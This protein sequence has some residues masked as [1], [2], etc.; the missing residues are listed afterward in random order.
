M[1]VQLKGSGPG[2]PPM[3]P[4]VAVPL[5]AVGGFVAILFFWRTAIRVRHRQRSKAALQVDNQSQLSRTGGVNAS[6]KKHI[7]YAPLWGFRHSREFRLFGL[8]M[9]SIP[10][11][12]EVILL[13]LYLLL[14]FIFVV[15]TVDWWED[16]S[17]K[18]F[19]LKYAAGHLAVMNTPGLVLSA[20]RNNPLVPVLG[21]SFD[22]FNFMH[23][24]VGRT[25]ALNAIIHMAAV[26]ANQAYLN[27]M[28]Y[29]LDTIWHMPFYIY[30]LVALLGFV[31]IFLQSLSPVRHSFYEM[32]LH[33]HIALAIMSFVALWYHLK[34]LLQ[35]RVLLGTVIIWG[36]DR[37]GRL[38]LLIWRNC[39]K[40]QT[41]ATVEALPGS[42]ARVDVE[43]SRAWSFRPGQYLY[44]YM[45]CL[46]LW[47]SHPFTVA[48]SSASAGSLDLTEK[49][50][51]SDSL[52]TLLGGSETTTMSVLIKGQDGFTRRLLDKV[53]DSPEGRI[54][55]T[56]LA[57]GPFGGIHSL[58]SYGTLL[59]VA[60]GI[61][62]TH[63]MSYLHEVVINFASRKT[64]TRKVHLVWM[65][66]SLDHLA[67]IHNWMTDI[68]NH[69]SLNSTINLKG[70][71]YFQFPGLMLSISVHVTEH[72]ETFE[73]FI[74]APETPWTQCA[75]SNVPVNVHYGKPSFQTLLENEKAEQVGALAV[76]VCGPGGLGDSVRE[77]VRNVQGERTVD[78]FEESFSW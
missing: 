23:R 65:I 66:R 56:A 8:H 43:V 59:L 37:V 70:E 20:G 5:F 19:Q 35:Q 58:A 3:N 14:N 1:G 61:G 76:S 9:G 11:R 38:V 29:I 6:L 10:L 46:G 33:L 27:G 52:A 17:K 39:G 2:E 7:F 78:L 21:L 47:T 42:V 60:G 26:L 71:T 41:T 67:W 15:V 16:F 68:F 22:T 24:W 62:I 13:A 12:L 4:F 49:R 44:L 69:D 53:E 63:P 74:P 64:A 72:K 31:F 18:M 55:A 25:I 48:W 34:N 57:E 75:P 28:N 30:G 50:S 51:S 36:L 32:F 45:P 54:K 77:A 73:E 40:R